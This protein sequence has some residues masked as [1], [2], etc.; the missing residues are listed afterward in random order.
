[1]PTSETKRTTVRACSCMHAYQDRHYGRNKRVFNFT[2]RGWRC[3]VCAR[4]II[5]VRT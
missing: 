2:A 5:E 1:M 4:D 3:T